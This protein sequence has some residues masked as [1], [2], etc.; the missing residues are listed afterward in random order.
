MSYQEL[1]NEYRIERHG[2]VWRFD[3]GW[4]RLTFPE[5]CTKQGA[6]DTLLFY[7]LIPLE[8]AQISDWLELESNNAPSTMEIG[9]VWRPVTHDQSD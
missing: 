2:G 7:S 6:L 3:A 1:T 5:E 9:Y 8:A 4:A